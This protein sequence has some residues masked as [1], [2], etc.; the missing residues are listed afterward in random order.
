MYTFSFE[1][2]EVWQLS[3]K[4]SVSVYKTT[5]SFPQS[6]LYGLTSQ[7]RRAAISVSSN[8]AEG[9]SRLSTKDKAHFFQMAFSSL[10]EV[11]NQLIISLDLNFISNETLNNYRKEIAELSNKLNSL[12]KSISN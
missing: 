4:L 5:S 12:H 3:R 2:L 10:M 11:M 8:I 7:L 6:E 9:N 1:K